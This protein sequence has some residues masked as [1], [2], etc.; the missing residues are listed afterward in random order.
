MCFI[1]SFCVTLDTASHLVTEEPVMKA[2]QVQTGKVHWESIKNTEA[3]N[4]KQR[5]G[6]CGPAIH[7][8]SGYVINIYNREQMS[9]GIH[10]NPNKNHQQF[11]GPG[12]LGKS[13]NNEKDLLF[14]NGFPKGD[15]TK[16]A[17]S[18]SSGGVSFRPP[19]SWPL[20]QTLQ[21]TAGPC[22]PPPLV[23]DK[24]PRLCPF[25]PG[26]SCDQRPRWRL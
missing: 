23:P 1:L 13:R 6:G 15:L 5:S 16:P 8:A 24:L 7:I 4:V 3:Q 17:W 18:G 26:C 12:A 2:L 20:R 9:Y 11:V 10:G 19:R 14:P 22:F 25:L 21:L